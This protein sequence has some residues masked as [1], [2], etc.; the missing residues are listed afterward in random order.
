MRLMLDGVRSRGRVKR[1]A[2]QEVAGALRAG[3]MH[4][5]WLW[6]LIALRAIG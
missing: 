2:I 6:A 1:A 5:A 3:K 4:R